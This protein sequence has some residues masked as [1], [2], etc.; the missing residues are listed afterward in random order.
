MPVALLPLNKLLLDHVA[1]QPFGDAVA[2]RIELDVDLAAL[3][4]LV[5]FVR[6]Y[7]RVIGIQAKL[8]QCLAVVPR[9]V[10]RLAYVGQVVAFFLK[11]KLTAR[12]DVGNHRR[13]V[14]PARISIHPDFM[15]R[16]GG[17]L[18]RHP[19]VFFLER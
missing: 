14:A 12:V 10:A 16:T 9:I 7:S 1:A 4:Q 17:N 6:L 18:H 13:L 3:V 2:V 15:R 11:L 5:A 19:L 8:G